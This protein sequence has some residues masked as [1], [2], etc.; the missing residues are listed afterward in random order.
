MMRTRAL[1]CV[2][3]VL[4]AS[5]L[6]GCS[7]APSPSPTPELFVKRQLDAVR[8]TAEDYGPGWSLLEGEAGSGGGQ[9]TEIGDEDPCGW[10]SEW[11]PEAEPF[12]VHTW[13]MYSA[14]DGVTTAADWIAAIEPGV[15]PRGLLEDFRATISACEPTD[16]PDASGGIT[17]VTMVPDIEPTGLGDASFAYRAD[18]ASEGEHYGQGEVHTIVCGQLW[19]HVSYQGYEPFVERDHLVTTLLER[20]RDLGGC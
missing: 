5:V 15:D 20:A 11:L 1:P 19:L 18:F 7:A 4:L 3:A 14:G 2:S 12:Y 16:V 10:V 17:T 13:R 8:L 6:A 9:G